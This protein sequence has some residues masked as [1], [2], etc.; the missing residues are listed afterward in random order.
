MDSLQRLLDISL[1]IQRLNVSLNILE[2]KLNSIS[3]LDG[4][5]ATTQ[6]Q[7]PEV[8][9]GAGSAPPAPQPV[10]QPAAPATGPA[11]PP[12][13]GGAEPIP[14]PQATEGN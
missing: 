4:I 11:P 1:R 2:A 10:S 9:A 7:P 3:S 8:L 6:Y 5:Q 12:S 13:S 14:P